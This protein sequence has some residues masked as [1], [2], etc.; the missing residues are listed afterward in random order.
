MG[1]STAR[2]ITT[3]SVTPA[4]MSAAVRSSTRSK[5]NSTVPISMTATPASVI[6]MM[7]CAVCTIVIFAPSR[8]KPRCKFTGAN[9][10]AVVS[11][12]AMTRTR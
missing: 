8:N 10:S 11:T 6:R 9:P 2:M 5:I 7:M 3:S 12:A 4:A 1:G